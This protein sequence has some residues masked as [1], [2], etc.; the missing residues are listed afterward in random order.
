[1]KNALAAYARGYGPWNNRLPNVEGIFEKILARDFTEYDELETDDAKTK[2]KK[3]S[4]LKKLEH[5]FD[6]YND[7]MLPCV[8]GKTVWK[9]EIRHKEPISV[10]KYPNTSS[11]RVNTSTE[12]MTALFYLNNVDKWNQHLAYREKYPNSKT[13]PFPSYSKKRPDENVEYRTLYTDTCVG[14]DLKGGWNKE[15]KIEFV[16]LQKLALV[17]REEANKDRSIA[18]ETASCDRL[19]AANKGFHARRTNSKKKRLVDDEMDC[20]A[21]EYVIED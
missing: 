16:R 9:P 8:A 15:G 4:D 17:A 20:D 12:A 21:L 11:N 6:V 5:F 19:Y 2:K 10:S 18:I 13:H 7:I 14:Q 1:M 3:A